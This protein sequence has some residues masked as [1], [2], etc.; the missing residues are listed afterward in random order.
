MVHVLPPVDRSTFASRFG[1]SLGQNLGE[2]AAKGFDTSRENAALKKRGIDVS[3]IEDPE[4]RAQI[5]A[6][7]LAYGR[8]KRNAEATRGLLTDE[9][10]GYNNRKEKLP[11]FVGKRPKNLTSPKFE[12]S[13]TPSKRATILTPDEVKTQGVNFARMSTEAGRPMSD[14][15][16]IQLIHSINEQDKASNANQMA[17]ETHYGDIGSKVYQA[18]F[19]EPSLEID[20]MFRKKAEDEGQ[21]GKSEA[22]IKQSLVKEAIKLKN[23]IDD[24]K[25][26]IKSQRPLSRLARKASGKAQSMQKEEEDLRKEIKPLLDAGLYD[27]TRAILSEGGK[28][29]EERESLIT[30]LGEPT[31]KILNNFPKI[32]KQVPGK[33]EPRKKAGLGG[34]G[35][36]TQ[37]AIEQKSEENASYT[38][39]QMETIN[40]TIK[41][42]FKSEPKAN[43]LLLRKEL[44][45][46]N[47]NWEA[48]KDAIDQGVLEGYIDLS[49][50]D[51]YDMY[52]L[53]KEP[54]LGDLD[55]EIYKLGIIGR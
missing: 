8:G 48:F 39:E 50:K 41:D 16:G 43:L 45:N 35:Y 27:E 18:Q 14:E 22:E 19:D 25:R 3:G 33:M 55:K 37:S 29:P 13:T 30:S 36:I 11:E 5:I 54:P 4:T 24:V 1:S 28:A 6:H 17:L 44:E 40:S 31:K 7:E 12:E 51:Q 34:F 23:K 26:A 20:A 9:E 10:K 15:E 53:L 42:I 2:G 32:Q 47:V 38:P 49:D 46:K 21:S 52:S